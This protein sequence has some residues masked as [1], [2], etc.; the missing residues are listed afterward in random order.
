MQNKIPKGLVLKRPSTFDASHQT[1]TNEID[2]ILTQA[3]RDIVKV[4][5]SHY[6]SQFS[7]VSK[8]VIRL[9]SELRPEDAVTVSLMA[10][11]DSKI[12]AELDKKSRKMLRD[13]NSNTEFIDFFKA[14]INTE[15]YLELV[16]KRVE[17]TGASRVVNLSK[18]V[19][20]KPALQVLHKGLNF[21]PTSKGPNLLGIHCDLARLERSMLLREHFQQR[22][23]LAEPQS[24]LSQAVPKKDTSDFVPVAKDQRLREY[25]KEIR[26]EVF[27][28]TS[29]PA[30]SRR[31]NL[32]RSE[33][34]A[35]RDLQMDNS[36]VIKPADKGG[37]I[38]IMDKEDYIKKCDLLLS[39]RNHYHQVSPIVAH[40]IYNRVKARIIAAVKHL[41][42]EI[43]RRLVN[44]NP[45]FG[46]FY[47][48]PKI[49]K[50][51]TPLRP[52]VASNNTAT[53]SISSFVDFC[54]SVLPPKFP[55]YI[56]DTGHFLEKIRQ[57]RVPHDGFILCTFDVTSLYTNIPHDDGLATLRATYS[58][59]LPMEEQILDTGTVISLTKIIL[60]NNV[61]EFN[62]KY[63]VQGS[64]TAMGTKMAPAYA[65]IFMYQLENEFL[66]GRTLKPTVY[67]RF[68]DD[69]FMLWEHG[70][71]TLLEFMDDFN[72]VHPSIKFTVQ[73]SEKE[74][75]FLDTLVRISGD[76]LT[77]TLY[78]KPTDN[79][80]YLHY[81][82]EHPKHQKNSIPY[83]LAL[84]CKRICSSQAD[85][86]NNLNDLEE[87]FL[88]RQYPK[89]ILTDAK[90]RV[91]HEEQSLDRRTEQKNDDSVRLITTYNSH[92]PNMQQILK[93]K[94][95]ILVQSEGMKKLF[96][97]A[98][99]VTFRRATNLRDKLV[100]ARVELTA[101]TYNGSGPCR[102]N[103]STCKY[104]K[105]AKS[106][107]SRNSKF[108]FEIRGNFDCESKNVVYLLQCKLCGVQYVGETRNAFKARFSKHKSDYKADWE[109]MQ[110]FSSFVKGHPIAKHAL[111]TGHTFDDVEAC[112]L[113]AGFKTHL[114]R[115]CFESWLIHNF[116][117]K[118]HGLNQNF[119]TFPL[120]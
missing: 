14:R 18:K 35:I 33:Q 52:I 13:N 88:D 98:P 83:S 20:P 43:Q 36:I 40:G 79:P 103:C 29:K 12:Q 81:F 47:G 86:L 71:T 114:E 120:C 27:S 80:I 39:D 65:N 31:Q 15:R 21:C 112:I 110:K 57:I 92:N 69:G 96:P 9:S 50:E 45:S 73:N 49:H 41:E 104:M 89:E 116:D 54:I 115:T 94:F 85:L 37:S 17:S 105:P 72:K 62:N 8:D 48:L 66:K 113:K 117:S 70:L 101:R 38:V 67:F 22:A 91:W 28:A 11:I 102:K 107:N 64:G 55:S 7:V 87:K 59:A 119:G 74:I 2:K 75:A 58:T 97:V 60:E 77:T 84:R 32:S 93:A 34:K 25:F 26:K 61:F 5:V 30:A 95:P 78:R 108:C 109:A 100:H 53:E 56:K 51:G 23:G 19:L 76:R 6:K 111:E 4:L 10:F 44:E 1:T 16:G 118:N 63:Y 82:S 46:R 3:S 99:K 68:L 24:S 106:I 90:R 42:P